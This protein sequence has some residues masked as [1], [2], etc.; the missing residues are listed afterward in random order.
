MPYN[1]STKIK[2]GKKKWCMTAKDTGKTYCYDSAEARSKGMQMHEA[3]S[4]GWHPTK[5]RYGK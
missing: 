1:L 5:K 3:Y 4:K 2:D